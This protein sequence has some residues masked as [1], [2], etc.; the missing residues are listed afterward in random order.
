[1]RSAAVSLFTI[2]GDHLIVTYEDNVVVIFVIATG[3]VHLTMEDF[4]ANR[5]KIAAVLHPSTYVNKILF[6]STQG[7]L[8]LWNIR[9]NKLIY[10]YK[11]F[12]SAV[13]CLTQS[14]AVD[15]VA[16][17][18]ANGHIMLHDLRRDKTVL[19]FHQDG[20]PIRAASFR[21]DGAP[22]LATTVALGTIALWHLDEAKLLATMTH[23]HASSLT[24]MEFVPGKPLL[25][26]G[27]HDN[28]MKLWAFD[29]PD[30]AGRLLRHREGHA[31]P[32]THLRFYGTDFELLSAS[33]D[34]TLRSFSVIRDERN[35]ELSQGTLESQANKK[36]VP[37]SALRLPPILDFAVEMSREGEWSNLVTCHSGRDAACLWSTDSKKLADLKLAPD[38]KHTGNN[39]YAT[40]VAMSGCGNFAL[41]GRSN[42]SVVYYNVQSGR[43]RTVFRSKDGQAHG[44][45][46]TAVTVDAVGDTC[47]SA[48][49][50]GVM[51]MWSLKTGKLR[52]KITFKAAVQKVE[53]F[54][55]SNI[56]AV[57]TA[58]N[59]IRL[60]D[61]EVKRI[62]RSFKGH[63][64]R[65][66]DLAWF[67]DGKWIATTSM[68]LTIR[69]WDVVSG[70]LLSWVSVPDAPTS[71]SINHTGEYLVT[72]HVD[73]VGMCLWINQSLY[74]STMFAPLS[75][76]MYGTQIEMG[77]P[78]VALPNSA[79]PESTGATDSSADD[80]GPA[81][82]DSELVT[83]STLPRSRWL[84]LSR[85]EEIRHRNR[86]K[87]DV[88]RP[89]DAPF[90]LQTNPGVSM[91]RRRF[92]AASSSAIT[93]VNVRASVDSFVLNRASFWASIEES[94][95]A[96]IVC[97]AGQLSVVVELMDML[98]S[99]GLS[100][101]DLELRSLSEA[102]DGEQLGMFADFLV[103]ML[104]EKRDI[105]LLQAYMDVFLSVSKGWLDFKSC[106]AFLLAAF[107]HTCT[108]PYLSK[109]SALPCHHRLIPR[110]LLLGT[111]PHHA[112][113]RVFGG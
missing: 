8:Q 17:G 50:D 74:T 54:R 67:P 34:R 38:S 93:A 51:K 69:V 9:S 97:L 58:D 105:E 75:P 35:R 15:V 92:N 63:D 66:T 37:L 81:Q 3:A 26:T 10:S 21:T 71:I 53:L 18:L 96:H 90:F 14:P 103:A 91:L 39:V 42:G 22:I 94:S 112:A 49:R 99:M 2:F 65:I 47:L 57:V 87:E 45:A 76:G 107:L 33:H 27:G 55:S 29:A 102:H 101:I 89:R 70:R 80:S 59:V 46:V 23:C 41:V 111:W 56:A 40:S 64:A 79:D 6:A 95:V 68:D 48:S 83:L 20:G 5:F 44:S 100:A 108:C 86:A 72:S 30:S 36:G 25:L 77:P 85:L 110:L 16:V 12:G 98:K 43:V 1:G 73:N 61:L 60:F 11:S 84:Y 82:L 106:P 52:T 104:A 113:A 28:A 62:V 13:T 7:E 32:I 78:S 31:A 4:D 88:I 109:R 19:Q 24:T